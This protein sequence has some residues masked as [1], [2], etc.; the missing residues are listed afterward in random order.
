MSSTILVSGATGTQG[1]AV[2]RALLNHGHSVR[3]MTRRPDG[4]AARALTALGAEVVTADF[5]DAESLRAAA[6]GVHAVYAMGTPYES[7]AETEERQAN[8]LLDA[9]VAAGVEFV[10][11]SS[12]ASA[13]DDSKV[14]HFDSKARVEEHLGTLPVA[15]TVVAPAMFTDN[16][17]APNNV[18]SLAAGRYAFPVPADVRVQQVTI[19]DLAEFT[20][21]VFDD[22]Q[23]FAGQRIELASSEETG[24]EV[25]AALTR[26]LGREIAYSEIPLEAIEA[27]G[28]D[29]LAAMMRFFRERGYSIDIDALHAAYPEVGWHTVENWAREQNW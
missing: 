2:A 1:G 24:A 10:V 23:R 15:H 3:A 25:A 18:E 26:V 5:D 13:L 8:A 29:D 14:P 11:Y 27:S 7:D 16:I 22:P 17:L 6:S 19:S 20:A 28:N 21:L 12:V 9:A 4:D